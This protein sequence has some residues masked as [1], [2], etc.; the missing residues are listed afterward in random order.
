MYEAGYATCLE[1]Y[2]RKISTGKIFDPEKSA[3]SG[4]MDCSKIYKKVF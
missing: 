2:V 4:A 1:I 3:L